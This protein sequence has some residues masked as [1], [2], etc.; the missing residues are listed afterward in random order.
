MGASEN[1][2]VCVLLDSLLD[3]FLCSE[4]VTFEENWTN[5]ALFIHQEAA[6]VTAVDHALT[7]AWTWQSRGAV[8][9]T[10]P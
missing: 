3:Y 5:L 1:W 10:V 7:M 4:V 2:R 9:S 8:G 6:V